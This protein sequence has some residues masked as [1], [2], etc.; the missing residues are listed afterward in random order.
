[1]ITGNEPVN[2]FFEANGHGHGESIVFCSADGNTQFFPYKPGI[3]LRQHFA[4]KAMQGYLAN[5][6]ES[7]VPGS[8]VIDI[9]GLPKDTKYEFVKHY[10]KYVAKLSVLLAD[11]LIAELNA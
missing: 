1:M 5:S 2:P 3:N 6:F 9:L 10:P 7:E 11:A 4:A 8:Y